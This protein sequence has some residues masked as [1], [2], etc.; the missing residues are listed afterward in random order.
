MTQAAQFSYLAFKIFFRKSAKLPCISRVTSSTS[1]ITPMKNTSKILLLSLGAALALAPTIRA[2]DQKPDAPSPERREKMRD[3]AEQMATELGLS[4]DQKAKFKDLFKQERDQMKAVHD[5]TTLSQDQKR[6][7]GQE[8]RKNFEAQ[9]RALMTPEQQ[10]KADDMRA[11]MKE[12]RAA[13]DGPPPE[14]N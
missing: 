12:H 3:R 2:Q 4:D 8:I 13:H 6:D 1:P 7:K 9:R 11:K 5:D 14:K 10:K